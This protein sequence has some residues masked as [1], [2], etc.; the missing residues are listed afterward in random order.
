MFICILIKKHFTSLWLCFS[1]AYHIL[2]NLVYRSEIA[3]DEN[4]YALDIK[5]WFV[6]HLFR[7]IAAPAMWRDLNTVFIHKNYYDIR[8]YSIL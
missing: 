6:G 7:F 3:V 5:A 4:R 1:R 8:E 2:H